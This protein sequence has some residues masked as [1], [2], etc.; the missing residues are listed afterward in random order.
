MAGRF[1]IVLLLFVTV[2]SADGN[3]SR[4]RLTGLE[5]KNIFSL[6]DDGKASVTVD[7]R[8]DANT[9]GNLLRLMSGRHV[10]FAL[11]SETNDTA[12]NLII[13]FGTEMYTAEIPNEEAD[14]RRIYV[15]FDGPQCQVIVNCTTIGKFTLDT[16]FEGSEKKLHA[17]IGFGESI[18]EDF[19]GTCAEIKAAAQSRVHRSSLHGSALNQV[20]LDDPR[21]FASSFGAPLSSGVE[22]RLNFLEQQFQHFRQFVHK[23]DSR[24]KAVELHQ[25]GCCSA[26][27]LLHC[28]PIGC[29]HLTCG[30]PIRMP[31]ECCPQCGKQCY[32][33]GQHYESGEDVWPKQC[34]RCRCDNGRM[35]CK[36]HRAEHCPVLTCTNQEIPPNHCCPVCV[37]QDH[38]SPALNPCDS[39]AFCEN[40]QYGPRCTCKPGFF[41]NGTTCFDVD[42]C[43]WD[44]QA[45]AQLGTIC[46]NLPGSFKCDCLPGFQRLDERNCLDVIRI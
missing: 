2:H 12:L 29:P 44:D 3:F 20:D 1:L 25:R 24:I 35:E 22:D 21:E 34:V 4:N 28:G 46:I 42:E 15:E 26:S 5:A 45:R 40:R 30:H 7:F 27:G 11:M 31:G 36:F 14:F 32:Y 19:P 43:L 37:N 18:D 41:G 6:F 16:K 38:C 17:E 9:K 10:N 13:Q 39:N 33:N 8:Q 23:V